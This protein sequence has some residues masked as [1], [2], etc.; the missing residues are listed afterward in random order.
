MSDKR[1][2][3]ILKAAFYLVAAVICTHLALAVITTVFCM[4]H[5]ITSDAKCIG[6]GK[7]SEI[8][9]AALAAAL[10][11]AGGRFAGRRNGDGDKNGKE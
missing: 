2:F 9:A 5:T 3:D 11:F 7:I 8:L 4:I 6:E 10:A 1:D